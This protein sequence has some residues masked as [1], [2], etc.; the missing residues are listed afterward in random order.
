MQRSGRGRSL[1]R[2]EI[3]LGLGKA[4]AAQQLDINRAVC[5]PT[6]FFGL[7]NQRDVG[8][9]R[10][11]EQLHHRQ[12][13]RGRVA[14][15]RPGRKRSPSLP[16]APVHRDLTAQDPGQQTPLVGVEDGPHIR[17]H[18]RHTAR[19][20]QGYSESFNLF[21]RYINQ[22][23]VDADRPAVSP[24]CV[25]RLLLT[26]PDTLT[27]SQRDRLDELTAACPEMIDLAGLVRGF[28]DLLSPADGN[29]HRAH[30]LEEWITTARAADLP[31]LHAFTRGLDLDRAAVN[32]AFTLPHHNSGTEDVN[33]KTKRIMRQ[34]HGRAGFP[35]LRHR[36]LLG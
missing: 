1:L 8:Q 35:L 6:R 25:T 17:G 13:L 9:V 3:S 28:A 24:R 11:V 7:P 18:H 10:C 29:A 12:H 20:E 16:A 15:H 31:H 19:K 22:G 30:R 5:V 32:A 23:H 36:I 26:R 34:M 2:R 33:T 4:G 21:V 14:G 27:D